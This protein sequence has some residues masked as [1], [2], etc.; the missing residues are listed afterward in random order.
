VSSKDGS[1]KV[2]CKETTSTHQ[3]TLLYQII[4][5]EN[6]IHCPVCV[7]VCVCAR[8]RACVFGV[9]VC[10]VCV[11]GWVH[12]LPWWAWQEGSWYLVSLQTGRLLV[13]QCQTSCVPGN[14]GW[15]STHPLAQLIQTATHG[16]RLTSPTPYTSLL[17]Q[18]GLWFTM[19]RNKVTLPPHE[20]SN[21]SP[22]SSNPSPGSSNPN[23]GSSR[24]QIELV[25]YHQQSRGCGLNTSITSS[26]N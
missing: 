1:S 11:W 19:H 14:N 22:G 3:Y 12:P 25:N 8:A 2:A 24:I 20:S 15:R 23:P 10:L 5:I 9:C 4:P 6:K 7:C 21:P 16:T 13:R 18:Q 17:H 26:A